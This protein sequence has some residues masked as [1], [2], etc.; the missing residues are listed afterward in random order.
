MNRLLIRGEPTGPFQHIYVFENDKMVE[1]IGIGIDDLEE[2]VFALVEKYNI[3]PIDLSG[4]RAYMRGIEDK[5][6]KAGLTEYNLSGLS[7]RYL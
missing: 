3:D 4:A 2:I 6:T 1:S 7:F 5:I